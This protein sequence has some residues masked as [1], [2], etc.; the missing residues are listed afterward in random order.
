MTATPDTANPLLQ[1]LER[2]H[3]MLRR[4]LQICRDLADAALGGVPAA[5]LQ[6]ALDQ[7]SSRSLLFQLKVN[8]LRYCQFVHAHHGAEDT[9][10]FPAVRASAPEL[11]PV[12]D[13]LEA[14]HRLV[15]DLLD[16]IELTASH[17]DNAAET[18]TLHSP[19]TSTLHGTRAGTPDDAGAN[20][21]H[22]AEASQLNSAEARTLHGTEE[23][24]RDNAESS[25]ARQRLA[26]AL[27][28]LSR[29]LLEHLDVE[30]ATLGPV[31]MT[32]QTWPPNA[33]TANN[34]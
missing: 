20:T 16:Q 11:G 18:S 1:E 3:T 19:E 21:L 13:R 23:S 25:P 17:L 6:A 9:L 34:P 7:L 14:D 33:P 12:I 30:E 29:H 28:T 5:D 2:V 26:D 15:S 22:G 8:C 27:S 24:P 4:D 10:L 31:F 32:W